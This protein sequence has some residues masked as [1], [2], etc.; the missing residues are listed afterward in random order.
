VAFA[1][2][3]FAKRKVKSAK[4]GT[5]FGRYV[6]NRRNYLH[7]WRKGRGKGISHNG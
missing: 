3:F 2:A 6:S 1:A 4:R 7:P 5:E